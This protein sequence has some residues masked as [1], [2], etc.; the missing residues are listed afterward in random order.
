MLYAQSTGTSISSEPNYKIP[1]NIVK[2][3]KK[4]KIRMKYCST[5]GLIIWQYHIY[6]RLRCPFWHLFNW[7]QHWFQTFRF[8]EPIWLQYQLTQNKVSW[9]HKHRC[10]PCPDWRS[11]RRFRWLTLSSSLCSTSESSA[12]SRSSCGFFLPHVAVC[13]G[14]PF[15][16]PDPASPVHEQFLSRP[17]YNCGRPHLGGILHCCFLVWQSLGYLFAGTEIFI[18]RLARDR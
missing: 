15:L 8:L 6:S 5:T 1:S 4:R 18:T 12:G 2:H 11:G 16:H 14:Y 10:L 13:L 9:R 17:E 7:V 3:N